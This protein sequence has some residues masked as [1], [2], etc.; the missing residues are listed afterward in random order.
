MA[1]DYQY[2]LLA[3]FVVAAIIVAIIVFAN[4]QEDLYDDESKEGFLD[5][6]I[7]A[8]FNF[9]T[10]LINQVGHLMNLFLSLEE[11]RKSMKETL[12]D[13]CKCLPT[14]LANGIRI[15]SIEIVDDDV[16]YHIDVDEEIVDMATLRDNK[17]RLRRL[18]KYERYGDYR[19]AKFN[20]IYEF[21]GNKTKEKVTLKK[22]YTEFW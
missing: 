6:I 15:V 19:D 22:N 20:V 5:R 3:I 8:F 17:K 14:E 2:I 4:P 1:I 12:D 16:V 11:I 18:V 10:F 7:I 21:V 13:D 9:I